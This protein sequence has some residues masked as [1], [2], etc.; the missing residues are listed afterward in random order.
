[1]NCYKKE[2]RSEYKN[3]ETHHLTD[4]NPKSVTIILN[5]YLL[6]N[7]SLNSETVG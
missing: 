7:K 4:I 5:L 6:S 1:M 2:R 3:T